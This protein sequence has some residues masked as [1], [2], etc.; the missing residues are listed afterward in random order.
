M[1]AE[2]RQRRRAVRRALPHEARLARS[3]A[4]CQK[5]LELPEWERAKTVLAFV[6]MRSEV[7][8]GELV[9]RARSAN[10][11]VAA[12]RMTPSF[13]DLELAEWRDDEALEESGMMFLQPPDDSPRVA[14]AEV[15][16]VLVPALAADDRGH[17]IGYGKG[18][19]DRLLPRLT[20][21]LRVGVIFDFELV[22]EVPDRPGD[23]RLD[24][25]VTDACVLR[26]E[27]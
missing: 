18:F 6:P 7:Q 27:R 15:D 3:A 21:A 26:I 17:R 10:K 24:L 23:Q 25:V 22:G 9:E 12:P 13:D 11:R 1:K 5:V 19:Y 2:I 20:R 14:E 16:L 8:V 4:I